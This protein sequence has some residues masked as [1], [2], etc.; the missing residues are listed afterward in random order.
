MLCYVDNRCKDE[1]LLRSDSD[2]IHSP[3]S[4]NRIL[5]VSKEWVTVTAPQA[6]MP[7]AMKEPIV[8]D[9]L[10]SSA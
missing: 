8:V 3:C 9:M 5:T 4:C 2:A 10:A 1:K 7:P 6:A